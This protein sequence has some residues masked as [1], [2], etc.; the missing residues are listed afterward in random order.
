[1]L[2]RSQLCDWSILYEQIIQDIMSNICNPGII[3][4][5]RLLTIG[6]KSSDQDIDEA[7]TKGFEN[8][9]M[10][11]PR[12]MLLKHMFVSAWRYTWCTISTMIL[13]LSKIGRTFPTS[14]RNTGRR[15]ASPLATN[16]LCL[17]HNHGVYMPN[18][19]NTIIITTLSEEVKDKLK[20]PEDG[21]N[22]NGPQPSLQSHSCRAIQV[23]LNLNT[24]TLRHSLVLVIQHHYRW[25]NR[26]GCQMT[27]LANLR[28]FVSW[29][30]LI[31]SE[32]TRT[33]LRNTVATQVTT[34]T[35]SSGCLLS[36][37]VNLTSLVIT[38][39]AE[40]S[41][42]CLLPRPIILFSKTEV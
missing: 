38:I 16:I 35:K 10:A 22:E 30:H 24:H 42:L 1:M 19:K 12:K 23:K 36:V 6:F 29:T 8:F 33:Q 17:L 27:S 11:I 9:P 4:I 18:R 41:Q 5:P 14:Q 34:L 13:L 26:E 20:W 28:I 7:D 39:A 15:L 21:S 32:H 2:V 37:S 31:C 3:L 40:H 25:K